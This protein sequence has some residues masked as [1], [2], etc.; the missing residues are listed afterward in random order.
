[1]QIQLAQLFLRRGAAQLRRFIQ[2]GNRLRNILRRT[3]AI[4]V[5][6]TAVMQHDCPD[7][8][9]L[10]RGH[11]LRTV[12]RPRECSRRGI[13]QIAHDKE[14]VSKCHGQPGVQG[15]LGR[16]MATVVDF[17][18]HRLDAGP[19]DIFRHIQPERHLKRVLHVQIK[20]SPRPVQQLRR[21]F[22]LAQL[23]LYKG[24]GVGRV[25]VRVG[26]GGLLQQK[27]GIHVFAVLH[28]GDGAAELVHG[29]AVAG[30]D[31][32]VGVR[33]RV[34]LR[35]AGAGAVALLQNAGGL[36][37]AE[38]LRHAV[39][40]GGGLLVVVGVALHDM[41]QRHADVLRFLV[42]VDIRAGG[43]EVQRLLKVAHG[44]RGIVQL[45][46]PAGG[47]HKGIGL[48]VVRR[49]DQLTKAE[50][51]DIHRVQHRLLHGCGVQLCLSLCVALVGGALQIFLVSHFAGRAALTGAAELR[52]RVEGIG[53]VW[54]NGRVVQQG[55]VIVVVILKH[56]SHFL[57]Q[58][59]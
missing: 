9:I 2:A 52:Q 7:L 25:W 47:G 34:V 36:G 37:A 19:L 22:L 27:G 41:G 49:C 39:V 55:F 11:I 51:R 1:M 20:G 26:L 40:V 54:V 50:G 17:F 21:G 15:I 38:L 24:N 43:H 23:H 18:K 57:S 10:I 4:Q 5:A 59:I 31:Q 6:M 3:C 56:R 8:F 46:R 12:M 44:A 32:A 13:I 53:A 29:V 28:Q 30:G 33:L 48:A 58:V 42:R 14:S 16:T 45:Q 35:C